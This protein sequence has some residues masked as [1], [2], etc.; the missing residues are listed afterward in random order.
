[1]LDASAPDAA[2]HCRAE[3]EA[4]AQLAEANVQLERCRAVLG[5]PSTLPPDAAQLAAQLQAKE[6]EARTL[7]MQVEQHAQ[8]CL[9]STCPLPSSDG[10]AQAETASYAEL[11]RL[12]AAWEALDKQVKSKVFDLKAMEDRVLKAGSD[13]RAHFPCGR[14]QVADEAQRAK[15]ENKFFAAMRDKEAVEN[16]RKNLARNAEKQTKVIEKLTAVE[17]SLQA[18]L[19][20]RR[21]LSS[22]SHCSFANRPS[23]TRQWKPMSKL[24]PPSRRRLQASPTTSPNGVLVPKR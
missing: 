8:V 2:A 1:V 19:V 6:E 4:R 18:Q 17:R 13:V 12:S 3:A 7:R 15:L 11:D 22:V 9:V 14:E 23:M 16:E 24:K 20:R 10:T 5:D 21:A